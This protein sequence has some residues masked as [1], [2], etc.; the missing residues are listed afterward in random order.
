MPKPRSK[1]KRCEVCDKKIKTMIFRG[2]GVCSD[3]CRKKRDGDFQPTT[4]IAVNEL[5]PSKRSS[6][7][8]NPNGAA[9]RTSGRSG[10]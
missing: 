8:G 1:K 2:S 7:G 6:D 4:L 10:W 9:M 3:D 5:A